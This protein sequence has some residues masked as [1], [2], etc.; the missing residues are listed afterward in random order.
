MTAVKCGD[1]QDV[2]EG[3]DDAQEGGH[4]PEL[5]PVPRAGEEA[6]DGSEA[7]QRLGAVGGEDIFHVADIAAQHVNAIADAGGE[8]LEESVVAGDGSVVVV[9]GDIT[10]L[11]V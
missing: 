4:L 10:K 2:H 1:G 7:A 9:F 3:E 11:E 8:T 6:S 5:I